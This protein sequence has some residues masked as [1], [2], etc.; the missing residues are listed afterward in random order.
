VLLG[1]LL[2]I[3]CRLH[4][5]PEWILLT[6]LGA[7]LSDIFDG[8]IARR[9]GIASEP[10]RVADSRADAWFFICVGI[11]AWL[12]AASV[13]RAYAFPLLTELVLQAAA[14]TYDLIRYG[15]I[16]SLHAYSAKLWGFSLY[17]ASAGLL[18]FHSGA[19]I[20]AVFGLG[21]ISAIDSMAIKLI[22]P[23]WQH[24]V[25]SAL[26]AWRMRHSREP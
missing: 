16:A 23:D 17:L 11:S 9:L 2:L 13:V 20:W 12:A 10:L 25:P 1:V 26:H 5:G 14:Y 3:Q 8:V 24:D 15:R 4:A 22:L 18:A 7:M 21:I 6:L 19:L